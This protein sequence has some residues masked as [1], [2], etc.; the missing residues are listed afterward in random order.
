MQPRATL[1]RGCAGCP[2]SASAVGAPQGPSGCGTSVRPDSGPSR[3]TAVWGQ[4]LLRDSRAP[5]PNRFRLY[6][7]N[8]QETGPHGHVCGA[9]A[10][11][12]HAVTRPRRQRAGGALAIG[13]RHLLVSEPPHQ[14]GPTL[15]FVSK[16]RNSLSSWDMWTHTAQVFTP[17]H[18]QPCTCHWCGG[19]RG[20]KA[21]FTDVRHTQVHP[22][23]AHIPVTATRVCTPGALGT[24]DHT[25]RNKHGPTHGL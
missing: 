5:K 2:A 24:T 16:L 25:A 10:S 7:R 22:H 14:R 9:R 4:E 18:S 12:T 8:D 1:H 11:V 6:R 23:N 17:R 3:N 20:R 15:Q 19:S 13:S 21:G